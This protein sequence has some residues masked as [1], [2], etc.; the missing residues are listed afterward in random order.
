[1]LA[2]ALWRNDYNF[3]A[4]IKVVCANNE[5]KNAEEERDDQALATERNKTR[6]VYSEAMKREIINSYIKFN[7]PMT[8]VKYSIPEG[9][10]KFWV[11]S[12]NTYG[13]EM[14]LDKRKFNKRPPVDEFDY[15]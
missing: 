1:M 14:F 3:H 2:N 10:L 7:G 9:T 8:I 11:A 4:F 13:D 6:K 12:Y 5:E 15:S